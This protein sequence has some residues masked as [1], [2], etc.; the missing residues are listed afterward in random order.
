MVFSNKWEGIKFLNNKIRSLNQIDYAAIKLA[1][2]TV[3]AILKKMLLKTEIS[4]PI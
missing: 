2:F 3:V 1:E 4:S